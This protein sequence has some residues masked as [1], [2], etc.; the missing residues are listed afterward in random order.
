M[1]RLATSWYDGTARAIKPCRPRWPPLAVA[2]NGCC[3][4]D[5]RQAWRVRATGTRVCQVVFRSF[6]RRSLDFSADP[7]LISDLA[8]ANVVRRGT[9]V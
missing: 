9:Y 8:R 6:S 7:Q 1:H 2:P 3:L 5:G 4:S